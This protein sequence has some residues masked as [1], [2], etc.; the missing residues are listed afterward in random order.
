MYEVQAGIDVFKYA[1]TIPE[2]FTIA[3]SYYHKGWEVTVQNKKTGE[4]I[5]SLMDESY[6]SVDDIYPPGVYVSPKVRV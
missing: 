2:A 4:L 5:L 3:I 1:N 6:G